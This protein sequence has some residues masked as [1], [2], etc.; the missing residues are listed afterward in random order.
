[1][2]ASVKFSPGPGS[3]RICERPRARHS[4]HT[5]IFRAYFTELCDIGNLEAL[6]H[7]ADEDGL[8]RDELRIALKERRH[9]ARLDQAKQD[10]QRHGVNAVPTFIIN[11]R[12]KI[13]GAQSVESFREQFRKEAMAGGTPF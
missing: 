6:L 4:F 3:K 10:A 9:A 7:L 5:R 8:D 13:V 12:H 1:M 2:H 11:G